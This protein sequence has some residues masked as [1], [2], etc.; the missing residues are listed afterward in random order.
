MQHTRCSNTVDS[1]QLLHLHK[2][3]LL[4][5][6]KTFGVYYGTNLRQAGVNYLTTV[7]SKRQYSANKQRGQV[8]IEVVFEWLS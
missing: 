3:T 8:V 5:F 2:S 4:A 7:T 1:V 6:D